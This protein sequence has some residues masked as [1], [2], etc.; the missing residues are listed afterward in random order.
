MRILISRPHR[1][2]AALVAGLLVAGACKDFDLP[3]YQAGNASD[4]TGSEVTVT[5][6]MT[7]VQGLGIGSRGIM[8]ASNFGVH[9]REGYI[10]NP[11]SGSGLA[12]YY[13]AI[14]RSLGSGTWG[15]GYAA[16]RQANVVLHALDAIAGLTDAQKEAVRGYTKT[17]M[18]YDL[19]QVINVMDQSGAA[20]DV[21]RGVDDALAPIVGKAQVL[22]HI[23]QLLDQ[24]AT[25]LAAGGTTFPFTMLRGFASF[26][27]P[28]AFLTVNRALK[29]RVQVYQQDWT[30]ALTSLGASFINPA[31][32]LTLGAYHTYGTGSGDQV[33]GL[34]DPVP[35]T[36]YAHN[37]TLTDAQLRGDGSRD[38]R[39]TSKTL[40]AS[41]IFGGITATLKWNIYKA[42]DDPD[43]LIRNE[44]L[45]LLRAEARWFSGDKANAIADLDSVRVKA[46]G[47]AVCGAV[48]SP[49]A[50]TIASTDDAFVDELLYNRRYSLLWE[51]GHRWIDMRRYGRLAQLPRDRP[52]DKIYP[53]APLPDAECIPRDPDPPGCAIPAM[54]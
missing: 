20:I 14:D 22:A 39:A 43:P 53:Y 19:L 42:Q 4:L 7:A 27:T 41:T 54:L 48:G 37:T 1:Q 36:Q 51:G 12:Q 25:H 52:Q 46:G 16:L 45:I 44:E 50:L 29:A 32:P 17:L 30:G 28:A 3:N 49:C 9:G 23:V 6:L 40:P 33:N 2:A 11:T 21:D 47:L 18:A 26:S 38:L 31:S 13:E 10:L 24:A 34:Y 35:R 8:S 15:S 5:T